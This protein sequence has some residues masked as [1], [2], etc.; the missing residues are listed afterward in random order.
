VVNLV[1]KDERADHLVAFVILRNKSDQSDFE[2]MQA[3][4]KEL[5][6]RI[7]DYMI[8]RRFV[9]LNEFPMTSNGKADRRKLL[10]NL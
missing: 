9:F 1:T 10:D 3:M 7:P 8:P 6:T 2:L 4:K 5:G